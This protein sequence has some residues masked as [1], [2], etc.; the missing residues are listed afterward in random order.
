MELKKCWSKCWPF[1]VV[2]VVT[3]LMIL[4]QLQRHALIISG[5]MFFHYSRFYDV[6][7]QLETKK[8]NYFQTNFGFHQS[9]RI[10]NALYGPGFAYLNGIIVSLSKSWY[11]YQILTDYLICLVGAGTMM[12]LLKYLKIN[13]LLS[14]IYSLLYI[15][16]G[17][18]PA[19][20]NSTSFN[21]WGQAF[22]PLVVLCGVKMIKDS[23]QPINWIQLM[24]VM[25]LL[26]QIHVLSTI[27]AVIML[28]PFFIFSLIKN[29]NSK[30]VWI[31]F[32]KALIGSVFLTANVWG[33]ILEVYLN[34]KV[35]ALNPYNMIYSSLSLDFYHG[36]KGIYGTIF[37]KVFPIFALLIICQFI[38]AVKNIKKDNI[39]AFV[40]I[41]GSILV[42]IASIYFPWGRVQRIFPVLRSN[43]QFPFRLVVIAYPLIICGFA[44]TSQ[45]LLKT[46]NKWKMAAVYTLAG[47]LVVES[48]AGCMV[49][50]HTYVTAR[51]SKA[52]I[53]KAGHDYQLDKLFFSRRY[54]SNPDYLPESKK[55][56]SSRA[57][58]FYTKKVIKRR[59]Q[60][61]RIVSNNGALIIKWNAKKSRKVA[62]PIVVY[63]NSVLKVNKKIVQQI[64]T[65]PIGM[66]IVKQVKGKNTA[67]LRYSEPIWMK[68]LLIITIIGWI[69]ILVFVFGDKMSWK[70]R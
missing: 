44:L 6:F 5:D 12:H 32:M 64:K 45:Y 21:G 3:T 4:P 19:Y 51:L 7:M 16:V 54:G 48:L 29:K 18:I 1:L 25:S 14:L 27:L 50:N 70:L 33:A 22:M 67:S 49:T 15:T 63:K 55:I 66:P 61:K 38:Y 26:A 41:W 40:T 53:Q 23:E 62:L 69:S 9:G 59:K 36:Y 60:F 34:N 24:L 10:I 52:K 37:G 13:K 17:M 43:F 20:M 46:K 28:I 8:F 57:A 58:H 42:G 30:K 65:N 47:I 68:V 2:I 39:N 56:S 35:F 31:P 11:G